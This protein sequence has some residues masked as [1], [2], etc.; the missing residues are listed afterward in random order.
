MEVL[1]LN[2]RVKGTIVHMPECRYVEVERNGN[3]VIEE[4]IVETENAKAKDAVAEEL[5]IHPQQVYVY[6]CVKKEER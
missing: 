1:V 3:D 4:T 2:H 5:G 6:P